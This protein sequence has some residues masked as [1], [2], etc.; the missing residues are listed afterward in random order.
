MSRLF[1][2]PGHLYLR[3]QM[4]VYDAEHEHKEEVIKTIVYIKENVLVGEWSN[5]SKL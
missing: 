1:Q 2:N 3:Y 4:L 5:F